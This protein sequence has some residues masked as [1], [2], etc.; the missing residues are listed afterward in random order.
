MKLDFHLFR[1]AAPGTLSMGAFVRTAA[2]AAEGQSRCQPPRA[3][4]LAWSMAVALVLRSR[5]GSSREN[6]APWLAVL[7]VGSRSAWGRCG[8]SCREGRAALLS[9]GR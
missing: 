7:G 4:L 8:H 1:A 9:C 6:S 2:G 3:F 5:G